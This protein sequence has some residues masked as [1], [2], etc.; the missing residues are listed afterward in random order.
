MQKNALGIF[1]VVAVALAGIFYFVSQKQAG[2]PAPTPTPTA[3]T[4]QP[5]NRVELD[6]PLVVGLVSWPGYAGAIVANNGFEPSVESLFYKNYGLK[7]K[8]V[9]IEDIDARG[10]AFVKGGPDGVDVVWSTVDF[11]ANEVPT[12]VKNGI[13]AKAFMQIDWSRGGDAIVADK[14]IGK[15]EDLKG[16]KISLVQYTP[17]H[18]LLESLLNTSSLTAEEKEEIRK[19]LVFSQDTMTARAAFISG[20]V[21]ATVVWEPDVSAALVR[22]GSNILTSSKE[23]PNLIAD[24]MAAKADFLKKYPKTVEAFTRGVFDGVAAAEQDPQRAAQLLMQ[25]EPLFE[26]LGLEKT[27]QSLSWVKWTALEDNIKM[28]G[29]DGSEPL[30]NTM[31]ATSASLW[32]ELGL[33]DDVADPS[34]AKDDSFLKS[35]YAQ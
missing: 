3:G 4:Q 20:Q 28:F 29:L 10:K 34:V 21:D 19:N 15:I 18:W 2:Q 5:S 25:N 23:N 33:I 27:L 24:V 9:L 12:Y 16:K 14:S 26:E 35:I 32:K 13:D 30:F 22:P 7:V 31:F 6:R 8:L 11:W 17:S 1:V